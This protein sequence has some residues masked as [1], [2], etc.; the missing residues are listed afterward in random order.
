MSKPSH[1]RAKAGNG[2]RTSED[3]K[4]VQAII[5]ESR[6]R[7]L[8]HGRITQW[9]GEANLSTPLVHRPSHLAPSSVAPFASLSRRRTQAVRWYPFTWAQAWNRGETHKIW[10][11]YGRWL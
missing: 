3:E 1:A 9:S 7:C 4:Q 2:I 6:G 8:G 10:I 11:V 5:R